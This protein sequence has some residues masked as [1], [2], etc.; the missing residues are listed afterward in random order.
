MLM[1]IAM[2]KRDNGA[3]VLTVGDALFIEPSRHTQ[4]GQAAT[5]KGKPR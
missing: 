1:D 3:V 4:M 2:M 5:A